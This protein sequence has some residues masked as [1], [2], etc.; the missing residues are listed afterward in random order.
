MVGGLRHASAAK[1]PAPGKTPDTFY[2]TMGP[3]K[4]L[5]VYE[6]V[7]P[8]RTVQPVVTE[9]SR[10]VQPL[11]THLNT[12]REWGQGPAISHKAHLDRRA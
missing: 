7:C 6:K 3:R 2:S 8:D 9:L 12:L 1:S 4:S 11:G 5:D 10:P